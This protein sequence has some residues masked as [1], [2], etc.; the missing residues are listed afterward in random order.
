MVKQKQH[1]EKV[2]IGDKLSDMREVS[3]PI[4]DTLR[5]G[6]AG[7]TGSGKSTLLTNLILVLAETFREQIQFLGV[8][9][10]NGSSLSTVSERF[11]R[12]IVT[13][14]LEVANLLKDFESIMNARCKFLAD[15]GLMKINLWDS[16]FPQ[17]V[18]VIDEV[19][20]L[21]TSQELQKSQ[22]EEIKKLLITITS[23][24]RAANMGFIISGQSFAY[25]VSI[26]VAARS[27]IL[28]KFVM[29]VNDPTIAKTFESSAAEVC[30]SWLLRR[31]GEFYFTDGMSGCQYVKGK[32]WHDE[33]STY[34]EK[35]IELKDDVL[36]MSQLGLDWEPESPF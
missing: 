11:S 12:E 32:T 25:D 23:R 33:P 15:N 24:C 20:S 30:P 6:I 31:P 4:V 13:D 2:R 1:I 16:Q 14:A 17:I 19:T 18:L 21:M 36:C 35:A 34:L 3:F 9:L 28:Q 29:K 8:D 7:T 5:V 27:N 26:P 10:K 22:V